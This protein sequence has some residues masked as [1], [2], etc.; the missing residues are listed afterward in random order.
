M[1]QEKQTNEADLMAQIERIKTDIVDELDYMT[2][3]EVSDRSIK[4]AS[5]ID[6]LIGIAAHKEQEYARLWIGAK[7]ESKTDR[8][9]DMRARSSDV[10]LE[11][12]EIE[13]RVKSLTELLNALKKRNSM[14]ELEAR[15]QH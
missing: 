14:L 10:Y 13:G 3:R 7:L 6:S 11:R 5:L 8:E 4:L 9:A 12:R 15:N 1:K 2:P